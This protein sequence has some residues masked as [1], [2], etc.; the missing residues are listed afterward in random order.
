MLNDM[1]KKMVEDN[2]NLIYSFLAKHNLSVEEWYDVAAIGLCKAAQSYDGSA[3]F[4]TLAYKVMFN[5]V[6]KVFRHKKAKKRLGNQFV[7]VSMSDI[8]YQFD[9]LEITY[10]E[11]IPSSANTEGVALGK[12]WTEWF[13]RDASLSALRVLYHR[14]KGNTYRETGKE[15]GLTASRCSHLMRD[16]GKRYNEGKN[17]TTKH[18]GDNE[19]ERKELIE[20]ILKMLDE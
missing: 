16:I 8:V 15:V 3:K 14:L 4:N 2:H 18:Y 12:I 13:I 17:C 1:Q 11:Y 5:E 6:C 10:D 9:K 7:H 19:A 20:K